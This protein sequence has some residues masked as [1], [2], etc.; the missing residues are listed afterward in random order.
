MRP[1]FQLWRLDKIEYF[2]D[3]VEMMLEDTAREL[4]LE[5]THFTNQVVERLACRMDARRNEEAAR[6]KGRRID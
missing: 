2:A 4:K 6:E 5:P 3:T 1:S